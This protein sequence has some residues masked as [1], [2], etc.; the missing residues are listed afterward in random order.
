M[1]AQNSQSTNFLPVLGRVIRPWQGSLS[2]LPSE[3]A[4]RP[5]WPANTLLRLVASESWFSD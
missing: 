3:A 4:L 2:N 5:D 1:G